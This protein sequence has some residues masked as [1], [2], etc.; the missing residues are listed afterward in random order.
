MLDLPVPSNTTDVFKRLKKRRK[1]KNKNADTF[2][3]KPFQFNSKSHLRVIYL[4]D[5][6]SDLF[7]HSSAL[8]ACSPI[9][10]AHPK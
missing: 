2:L 4:V 9:R 6:Y 7:A 1:N 10:S 3:N 8:S 5:N